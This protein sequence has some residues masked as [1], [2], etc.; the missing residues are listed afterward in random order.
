M[1]IPLLDHLDNENPQ[2]KLGSIHCNHQ[3]TEVSRS[4]CS[5]VFLRFSSQWIPPAMNRSM[6]QDGDEPR[7]HLSYGEGQ[8]R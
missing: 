3:P 6:S 2:K 1:K 8:I 7:A 5:C 4:R